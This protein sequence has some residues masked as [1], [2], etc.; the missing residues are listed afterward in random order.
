MMTVST[1]EIDIVEI[2]SLLVINT[3]SPQT[4][5]YTKDVNRVHCQVISSVSQFLNTVS[6]KPMPILHL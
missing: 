5:A 6:S 3:R 2:T 1:I 4:V